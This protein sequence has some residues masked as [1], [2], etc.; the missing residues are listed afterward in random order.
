MST[1]D[2]PKGE[3]AVDI[4]DVGKGFNDR[5]GKESCSAATTASISDQSAAVLVGFLLQSA[6]PLGT[7]VADGPF[8]EI[9][10]WIGKIAFQKGGFHALDV[11]VQAQVFAIY[12]NSGK[13]AA[14]R[15]QAG[16]QRKMW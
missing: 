5:L 11:D 14:R 16:R 8:V 2:S 3:E 12:R 15:W 13:V 4:Y 10:A 1:S 6:A 7:K 9:A